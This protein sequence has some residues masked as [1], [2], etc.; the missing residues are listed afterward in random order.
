M[1][2]RLRSYLIPALLLLGLGLY[3]GM[4]QHHASSA[5]APLLLIWGS[6]RVREPPRHPETGRWL[7]SPAAQRQA[8]QQEITDRRAAQGLQT[9][10]VATD[11]P[12]SLQS[13][14]LSL[15]DLR[16][17]LV[18]TPP[19]QT[20]IENSAV[21]TELAHLQAMRAPDLLVVVS[22]L[23]VAE[24]VAS[25]RPPLVLIP[26]D[27]QPGLPA[28]P[29]T[30]SQELL[31]APCLDPRDRLGELS[32]RP[33]KQGFSLRARAVDMPLLD[34]P[35]ESPTLLGIG[36]E[37]LAHDLV[38]FQQR[39][40]SRALAARMR[41]VTGADISLLNYLSVRD[42]LVGPVDG[43]VLDRALPFHNQLVLLTLLGSEI[44]E[45]LADNVHSDTR[46]LTVDGLEQDPSG[47]WIDPSGAA[48]QPERAYRVAT[49]DYLA[50]GARGRRPLFLSGRDPLFT[51]LRT[52]R[53]ALDLLEVS[54]P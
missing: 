26:T 3:L 49:V 52:D 53:L 5:E 32:I 54:H 45:I 30:E 22:A 33:L 28:E 36:P 8:H 7:W 16:I 15:G 10:S 24:L 14:E 50:K 1:P 25:L 19:S 42:S 39:G 44:A 43:A 29:E 9:L 35:I 40:L 47:L 51:G 2:Q 6:E 34:A 11:P 17:L 46:Y 13:Q 12:Q 38:Q 20:E 41:A 48:L 37:N 27:W 31:I 23:P 4:L 18:H 21:L